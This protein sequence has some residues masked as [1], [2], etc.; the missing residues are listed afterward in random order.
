MVDLA[1]TVAKLTIL[2]VEDSPE[3]TESSAI[4]PV[5]QTIRTESIDQNCAEP[6]IDKEEKNNDC[7][8]S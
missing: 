6:L 3:E 5:A 7:V 4:S 2:P 8:L 1:P